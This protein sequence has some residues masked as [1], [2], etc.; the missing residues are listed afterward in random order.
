MSR[1]KPTKGFMK[2]SIVVATI[3]IALALLGGVL[4]FAQAPKP[5]NAAKVQDSKLAVVWTSG[6]PEV[7]HRMCLMYC[8]AAMKQRWFDHVVLIVWGP[9]AC[10]LAADKDLQAKV[11]SMME[12]GVQV[13]A[14]VAC[15][16]SYGVSERLR[17]MKIEV[18]GMGPPLT[19]MLK[20]GWKVLTF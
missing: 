9:S 5:L 11:K 19:E 1:A 8:H 2:K 15:A 17:E 16:D 6:D 10:L 4:M 18:K 14:C 7:A 20:Q 3:T 12:D 13:Q